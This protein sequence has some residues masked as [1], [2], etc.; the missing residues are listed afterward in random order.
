M[1]HYVKIFNLKPIYSQGPTYTLS[2]GIVLKYTNILF[3]ELEPLI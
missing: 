1:I 3:S 2:P